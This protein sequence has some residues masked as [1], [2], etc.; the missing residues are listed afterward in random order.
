MPGTTLMRVMVG[1]VLYI[2]AKSSSSKRLLR[3]LVYSLRLSNTS[4]RTMASR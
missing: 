4:D 3:R 1:R 2:L